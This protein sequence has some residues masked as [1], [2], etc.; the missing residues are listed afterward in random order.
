MRAIAQPFT[1]GFLPS[2]INVRDLIRGD[3]HF[4][5]GCR[6]YRLR[7]LTLLHR[8]RRDLTAT[9]EDQLILL[10]VVKDSRDKLP[11]LSDIAEVWRRGSV[12]SS[13][14]LDLIAGTLSRDSDLQDF[15]GRVSDSGEG[16]WTIDAAIDEGAPVPVLSAAL[17]ARCS[18][19][20]EAD[21]ANRV[22]SAMRKDFGAHVEKPGS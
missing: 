9:S 17:F 15:A 14:L 13:W 1:V 7:Q 21:F 18:S 22:L 5:S 8:I 12:I 6:Q 19:R 3:P 10:K 16:R 11:Y 4:L 2:R 20:G